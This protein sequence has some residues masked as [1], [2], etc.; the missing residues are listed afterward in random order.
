M[1]TPEQVKQEFL[2]R[3]DTFANYARRKGIP[4]IEVYRVVNG[5][6]KSKYGR[7]HEIAVDLG[8]KPAVPRAA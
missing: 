1:K 5:Q 6:Y 7:A 3:G 4:V 2:A 8:L